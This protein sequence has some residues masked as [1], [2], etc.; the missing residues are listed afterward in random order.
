MNWLDANFLPWLIPVPPLLAFVAI[1]LVTGRNRTLSH[2]LAIGGITLSFVMSWGVVINALRFPHLGHGDGVFGSSLNW[3]ANG[4][5]MAGSGAL[6]MGVFVDPLNHVMLFMVPLACLLIFIYSLG[7]MAHDPRNT[8]FFAYLSL[9]AAAMLTL[10]VADNLLLLFIGWEVMGLCSYLLI[11]FWFEKESAYKAAIKAFM[12][13]R[14]ADVIMLIGIGYLWAFT[15]TL[16]FRE[17]F[18]NPETLAALGTTP[19]LGGF[20]GLTAAG[21]IGIC[22]VTG[23]IGKS[24]QFPLHIWLPDAMEGPTPVSAMIHAAAMVSAGIYMIVR[25]FPVLSAGGNIAEGLLTSPMVLMA[26][27]GSFTALFAASIALTQ[28]DIKKVLAYSTISQLGFMMAALGIGA[29]IAAFFHLITHAFFKALLFLGSGSVIHAMEHGHHLAHDAH[30]H[31]DHADEHA[32]GDPHSDEHGNADHGHDDHAHG[33]DDFDPQDM[34]NMGGLW[35]KM[36]VTTWTFV[37]GGLSLAGFPLITAGFWSKDEIFA[38]AWH[39]GAK[40]G[41]ALLV[42]ILLGFAALFTALYTL[43]Q[44]GMTFFGEPR[45]EAAR[46][47]QHYYP[48]T[49]ENRNISAQ[50]TAPLIVLA[51]FAIV[52]GF[53]GVNPGFWILGPALEGIGIYA[54]FGHWVGYSLPVEPEHID[55]SIFPVI[56]SFGVFILGAGLGYR[57]YFRRRVNTESDP[58]AE[59]M[60]PSLY[61]LIS[62]K[63]YIEETYKRYLVRPLTWVSEVV[64]PQ[65]IDRGI[66]DRSLHILAEAAIVIGNFIKRFNEVVIDGVGDG[67]PE[68]IADIGRAARQIQNGRIQRYL[69]YSLVGAV[70]IGVN[71]ALI[72]LVPGSTLTVILLAELLLLVLMVVVYLAN[73]RQSAPTTGETGGTD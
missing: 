14:V 29:Y 69:L 45:T 17:I 8:R 43:R 31:E 49:V 57:L 53:A 11:G 26:V 23:T 55:F 9:F 38:E 19:A 5:G 25:M 52:A 32:H 4:T 10:V 72:A 39:I 24:A 67:I 46:Y 21:L 71:I 70:V 7:Y 50:L 37:I 47:A 18:F 6:N 16:N 42:L 33:H 61:K 73:N 2:V 1:I 66:I 30:G 62:N 20:L 44:I 36:P 48:K 65:I 35:R 15:G 58:I 22:I 63:Y 12:T 41:L 3:L 28:N 34:R 68:S 54:P 56:I 60:G 40:N 51:F 64:T 27:V 13:T 59:F